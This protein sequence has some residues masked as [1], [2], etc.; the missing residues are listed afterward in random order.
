MTFCILTE[1]D[2]AKGDQYLR[3]L[4]QDNRQLWKNRALDG[5]AHGF[6]ILLA[7]KRLA[8]AEPSPVS[9]AIAMKLCELYLSRANP[10]EILLDELILRVRE[11]GIGAREWKVG[12][13]FFSAQA[14]GRWWQDHRIPGGAGFSMNSV[15]HMARRLVEEAIEKN[16][17]LAEKAA[18]LPVER[19]VKWALPTAMR[20]IYKASQGDRPGTHLAEREQSPPPTGVSEEERSKILGR[21]LCPYSEDFYYGRY[22]TDVTIPS[23]YFNPS[24]ACPH[25]KEHQL[26][27]TYL[28]RETDKDYVCMGIGDEVLRALDLGGF[29]EI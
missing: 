27:F 18:T 11:P 5:K 6:I 13:N 24:P 22:D 14:D 23:E 16:P 9:S 3:E 28:H 1:T 17:A 7:S 10:D 26:L 20:T 19:L 4:I 15:G 12:V 29:T 25:S 2:I 21:A 8:Y